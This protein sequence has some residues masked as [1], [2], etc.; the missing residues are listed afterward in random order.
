VIVDL[1]L[2]LAPSVC[3]GDMDCSGAVDFNDIDRFVEALGYPGGVGWPY[4]GC[5][6]LAGDTNGDGNVTFDDIDPFVA[7]IG[8]P[9]P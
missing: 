6:W 4:P 1:I 9:C 2:P 5:P 3:P 8:A 7:V